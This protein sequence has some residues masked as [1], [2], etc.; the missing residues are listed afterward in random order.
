M[1]IKAGK[2][3]EE[4][5]DQIRQ[6]LLPIPGVRDVSVNP[7]TGS[8]VMQYDPDTHGEFHARMEQH[9]A[10]HFAVRKEHSTPPLS[11]VDELADTIEREA[12]YLA[13]HSEV[14]RA[15]VEFC[16]DLDKQVKLATGNAVDLK[17]LVPLGLAAYTFLYI[18]VEAATPV[19]L[20]LG[21][22]AM[23]HFVELHAHEAK[24]TSY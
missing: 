1:K 16:R 24:P 12:E 23:N 11:E 7:A 4:L 14:A 22:F 18:G 19:W 13:E 8:V 2:G 21:L 20:T 15:I 10:E 5:L 17:V 6:A 9:G 3:N